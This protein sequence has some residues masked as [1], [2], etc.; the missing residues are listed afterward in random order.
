VELKLDIIRHAKSSWD[1]PSQRDFDRPLN[2]RGLSDAPIM[3]KRYV[4]LYQPTL[5]LSSDATRAI[6]TAVIFHREFPKIPIVKENRIY[7]A[8]PATLINII[9]QLPSEHSHIALFGHQPGLSALVAYFTNSDHHI[10]TCGISSLKFYVDEWKEC[11]QSTAK[12][13]GFIYPRDGK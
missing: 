10:P 5:L 11:A 1:D 2:S 13:I 3:A 4:S 6:Q 8:T 9:S 7:E 12:E